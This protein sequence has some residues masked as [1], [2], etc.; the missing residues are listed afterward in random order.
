MAPPVDTSRLNQV[1]IQMGGAFQSYARGLRQA[2]EGGFE[3][4]YAA[5]HLETF[6]GFRQQIDEAVDE[7]VE[8]WSNGDEDLKVVGRAWMRNQPLN[9]RAA[10]RGL[11][12]MARD[13]TGANMNLSG[14]ALEAYRA[15]QRVYQESQLPQAND[16]AVGFAALLT[17]TEAQGGIS[18]E[19]VDRVMR[20]AGAAYSQGVTNEAIRSAVSFAA[21][22]RDEN[23]RPHAFA[24]V[25]P[26]DFD[27]SLQMGDEEGMARVAN[28][29]GVEP[30]LAEIIFS[31]G[32]SSAA[33]QNFVRGQEGE[34]ADFGYWARQ[35]VTNQTQALMEYLD[36]SPSATHDFRPSEAYASL[37][38]NQEFQALASERIRMR[39][40]SSPVDFLSGLTGGGATER[41][42]ID[43]ALAI[44]PAYISRNAQNIRDTR[45]RIK[46]TTDP[47]AR[48]RFI[49]GAMEELSEADENTLLRAI[50]SRVNTTQE[51]WEQSVQS[52]QYGSS[53]EAMAGM[54]GATEVGWMQVND[55][56]MNQRFEDPAVEAIR[57][58]AA[59]NWNEYARIS[60]SGLQRLFGGR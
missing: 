53:Q 8:S 18:D 47:I 54:A 34:K 55:V 45:E 44:S 10:A 52:G 33:W 40:G 16:P 3:N 11:L 12:A 21:D 50:Q 20:E 17:R 13:N 19:M 15:A 37:M 2:R 1:G 22:L 28:D 6:A 41:N 48:T 7:H 38:N 39:T 23:G 32:E 29:M 30:G 31:Q 27:S 9:G 4:E 43:Y 56:V 60:E 26:E 24:Q 42:F 49:L 51:I 58:R 14:P 35:L 46:E 59:R 5:A 57:R 25:R 36:A